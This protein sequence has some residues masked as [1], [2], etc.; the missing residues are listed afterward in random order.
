MRNCIVV[1]LLGVLAVIGCTKKGAAYR[2]KM[3]E[4]RFNLKTE[5]P[6]LDPRKSSDITSFTIINLCFEGLL[7]SNEVGELTLA[8]AEHMEIS[9][10]QMRYTFTLR[11]A[12]WSDGEKV[13]AYDFEKSWKTVL[14]PAFP[15]DF[16]TNFYVIKHAKAAKAGRC[17]LEEVGIVALDE[18]TLQIDLEHPASYFLSSL[19]GGYFMPT[20]S[21]LTEKYT[22]WTDTHYVAN[23]PFF[24]TQHKDHHSISLQKNPFYWDQKSIRLEKVSFAMIED[25]TTE[26]SMFENAELDWAGSPLSNL[27]TEALPSLVK[28]KTL[29]RY[30]IAGTY[31]YMF[32]T[33]VFPFTNK[34][35]RQAFSLAINR[36]EIISDVTQ[37][38][39]LAATSLVPP[40]LWGKVTSYF[41]DAS[42]AQ[43]RTYFEMG[44]NE[45][46]ITREEFPSV[47]LSYNSSS[48]HHKIA[49]AIQQQWRS[50]LGVEVKL[51]NKEWKVF[52]GEMRQGKFQIGRM[53]SIAEINDPISFLDQ[54]RYLSSNLN[55]SHWNNPHF[56]E[57]LEQ[58]DLTGDQEKR[59]AL[60]SQAEKLLIEEMPMA[61]IY[62]YTGSY[63]KQPY[64]KGVRVSAFNQLDLKGAYVEIN[65]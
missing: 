46:G 19:A 20:P 18:K 30:D 22:H 1:C 5:P 62:F 34:H 16:V 44:L 50:T 60:L 27:P 53:G 55:Y 38:H 36:Q 54:Y 61:P 65:D 42:S 7:R 11:D 9:E 4:L 3:Q 63:I 32:N 10:D 24:L 28:N 6:T 45:L 23:G 43:A 40:L 14:D 8:A 49:Q 29:Q 59:L 12:L 13:T 17:S 25:E 26:L 51:S 15:C 56:S 64:V 33:T 58:A 21:H 48:I 31:S 41:Q 47:S 35:I 37:M 52:L 2:P 57:L 39:Q